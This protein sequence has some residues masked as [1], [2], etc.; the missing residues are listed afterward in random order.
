MKKLITLLL[1]LTGCVGTMSATDYYAVGMLEFIGAQWDTSYAPAKMTT[2]DNDNYSVTFSNVFLQ[3]SWT[4]KYQVHN[5]SSWLP[6]SDQTFSVNNSGFYNVTISYK[7]STNAVS[8]SL[9]HI[10]DSGSALFVRG[11]MISGTNSSWDKDYPQYRVID[12]QVTI[13]ASGISEDIE[14]KWKWTDG[15]NWGGV[16]TSAYTVTNGIASN[17]A[18]DFNNDYKNIVLPQST[19][20]CA[21]YVITINTT[22]KQFSVQ[23][24]EKATTNGSGFATFVNTNPL[25]IPATTAYYA[26]DNGNG[27]AVAHS[28]TNP[29]AGTAMLI[30]GDN[31]TPYYFPLAASGTD[32][33]DN[34]AFKAGT[35]TTAT[36]GLASNPSSGVYNYVLNGNTFKAANDKKVAVGKAYLQLSAAAPTN[37]PV[38]TFI[39][40][41]TTGISS[42]LKNNEEITNK[43][44]YDLQGRRVVQPKKGLYIMNGKKIVLK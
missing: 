35:S 20:K 19:L 11:S 5:G 39:D 18:W 43:N 31:S 25:T 40:D 4:Y 15:S 3:K 27:T 24:Y 12:N 13:D 9:T 33:P 29:V 10:A 34:N 16:P 14:I 8:S 6:G 1:V 17:V 23:G 22:D 26:T 37:S 28:M 21:K 36:D 41:F 44:V 32:D 38:L 7:V 30:K 2:S 42:S